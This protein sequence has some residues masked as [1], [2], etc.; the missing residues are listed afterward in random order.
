MSDLI[1]L[2]DQ[3][4]VEKERPEKLT[5]EEPNL[6]DRTMN[7]ESESKM[8]DLIDRNSKG[9]ENRKLKKV[10]LK[11]TS[12]LDVFSTILKKNITKENWN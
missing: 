8:S 10:D 6:I 11:P 9:A 4:S 1:D 7:N 5:V 12:E 3:P 2:I